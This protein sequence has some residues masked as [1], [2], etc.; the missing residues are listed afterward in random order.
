MVALTIDAA[1]MEVGDWISFTGG[2]YPAPAEIEVGTW[3]SRDGVLVDMMLDGINVQDRE[4]RGTKFQFLSIP[5][6]AGSTGGWTNETGKPKLPVIRTLLMI[7]S[8]NDLRIQIEDEDHTILQGYKVYPVGK[9]VVRRG[10]GDTVYV[11]EEFAFDEE[12]YSTD[13]FYPHELADISFSGYLRDQRLV[14]LEFHPITYN[15]PSGELMCYSF[16]SVRVTYAGKAAAP[17]PTLPGLGPLASVCQHSIANY[18]TAPSA[19]MLDAAGGGSVDYPDSLVGSHKADYVIIAPELFYNSSKLRQLADWRAQYSGLDVVLA[20]TARLYHNFGSGGGSDETI[21]SF[22]QYVYEF[23]SAEHMPDGRVGYI[24]L[25]GDV[26]LLPIHISERMSFDEQIATDNWYVCVSGD[27]LMPDIMLGRLP[28]KSITE[29]NTMIDKIIQYEQNPLYGEWANNA[30]MVLGTVESL[31]DDM[32]RARDEYLLP[33][34]YNV[35]EVSALDGGSAYNV[36]AEINRGQ[37]IVDYAGHGWVNGWEIFQTS[38][39]PKLRNDG[40]LPAIFSLACS[41]GYFDH[42]DTDSLAEAFLKARNG[43]IAFFGSSRLASISDVGFGLSEAVAES[44]IYT[45]GEITTYVKLKLLPYSSNMELYNLLGDPGLDLCAARRQPGKADLVVSPVDISFEPEE[46]KQG[47]QMQIDIVIHNFGAA[48]ARDIT[49]ELRDGDTDETSPSR[50]IESHSISKILAGDRIEIETSW[51]APLGEPQHHIS[52]EAHLEDRSAEY[53]RENND[54]QKTLLVSLE[55]EGWP[56]E[57]QE[58]TLSAPI[59][60]DIDVDGDIELLIQSNVYNYNKLYVW[61]HDGQSVSGWPRTVSQP[62]YDARSYYSNSSAGPAPAVGDIDG[63]GTPEIVAAFFASEVRAWRSDGSILPGWPV[64]TSGY[65]SS[66]PVL[67]DMDADGK[68][69]IAFGLSNGRMEVRRYDGSQFPG[70]PISVGQQGHLF[71]IVIDMD[72]D[73]DLE[74][75]ALHSPIPKNSGVNT[76]TL[77]AWHHDGTAVSGWPVRMQGADAILPPAAGDLDGDGTSEIVAVSVSDD[78]CRI[79]VWEHNGSLAQGWPITT[80]DK[81][82]SAVALGDLDQDG[83]VEIIACSSYDLAYA[84]HHDGRRVFGWPVSIA[85]GYHNSAPV[86]ADVDGD[87]RVDVVFASYGGVIYAYRHDGVPSQGWPAITETGSGVSPPVIADM[88]GDGKTELAYA[89]NSGRVH[90]LS[91]TGHYGTQ[92][93]IEWNMFSHDQMH[94]GSYNAKAILPLPPTDLTASDLPDDKG[95]SIILSWQLSPDDGGAA[96]YIVYRSDSLDGRYS[97]V[98][99]VSRGASTYTDDTAQV[100]I[101]YWYVVRASNGTYLSTGSNPVSAYSFNNFAPEPPGWV[102]AHKGSMD[103]TIDVW[104]LVGEEADL[105]GYKVYYSGVPPSSHGDPMSVGV[106]GHCVVTG[107]IN[108]AVYYV[109]V[110]AYDTEGNE[111]LRS[112]EVTA[113]PGDDDTEPPSFSAFYPREVAEGTAFYIKC[114]ISD[115]SGVYDDSSGADGQG[116]Y[117]IWDNDDELLESSRKVRMSLLSPGVYIT[118]AKISG[119]SVGDQFIYQIYAYDD[120][121]DWG[122]KEDRSPGISQEQTVKVLPSPSRAYNY[123]N[124]APAGEYTDKTIFRYYT[125]SDADVE[126]SIYDIAG[127]LVDSLEAEAIGGRYN[128]TEWNISD[129]ASGVYI[130]VIEIQ[131]ASGDKQ[132]IEKKLAIVK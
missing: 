100:G 40:K 98:G 52:V 15:P 79:Y 22:I 118:D 75:A 84:W 78:V 31:R 38:D 91:L 16:L 43:A 34:G 105:A 1:A 47:E 92:T 39:I 110:A 69:E 57:V 2:G 82:T 72:G 14:Q 116:V 20:S 95:G 27:D 86:L 49:V 7:P 28:A 120:D 121:C 25:V 53:Y 113:T 132:V 26:E 83:D 111:S 12:F 93:G 71:P 30:L 88:D 5:Q 61:H 64:S 11:D 56:V 80:D 37:Q 17:T 117:L 81:I 101:T 104:W 90:M 9:E 68:L 128:E 109:S 131:P 41:T 8:D 103:N 3:Q 115:P 35:S 46:P 24:L 36:V 89:S 54:A 74:L 18:T 124:P 76:S 45:L 65:A 77:Y 10:R 33:A 67:A 94:T 112:S 97:I 66:S 23:W 119:Q 126:I 59:A 50:L 102:Y 129:I 99:K 125:N 32:E 122:N 114:G 55:A 108:G 85:E 51:R 19:Y 29:L 58:R 13:G 70:W 4:E 73:G 62:R 127:H 107:L 106:T 48:D 87:D 42:P 21:R 44:H 96:G 123:P 130:Y 63:D 60:A 6:A